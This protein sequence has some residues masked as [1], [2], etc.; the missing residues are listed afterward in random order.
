MRTKYFFFSI[1]VFVLFIFSINK[2]RAQ[3]ILMEEDVNADTIPL[4]SGPNM[5]NFTHTYFRYGFALGKADS[6]GV[7]VLPG[8]SAGFTFGIRYKRRFS[9]FYSLGFDVN[10]NNI[11]YRLKQDSSKRFPDPVLHDKEKIAFNNLG[12]ELY[13]RFNFGKRGNILGTFIDLGGYGDWAFS[14]KHY[15][16]DIPEIASIIGANS[17]EVTNSRLVFV[18][19]F[20]YGAGLKIG[21][22]RYV[23]FAKYRLSNLFKDNFIVAYPALTVNPELPRIIVGIEI[24]LLK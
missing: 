5:K 18:N 9:N 22:N 10:Y 15:Y 6:A 4:S 17:V 14:V 11:N 3:S 1:I 21:M 23:I 13:N 8:A 20:N 12:F 24:G 16:K 2:G 7:E 19:P